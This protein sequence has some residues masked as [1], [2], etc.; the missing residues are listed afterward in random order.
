MSSLQSSV[1]RLL[2]GDY[3]ISYGSYL[4]LLVNVAGSYID[5]DIEATERKALNDLSAFL[6]KR[7]IVNNAMSEIRHTIVDGGISINGENCLEKM[8]GLV[9][10]LS[11]LDT[12]ID[13]ASLLHYV[14]RKAIEYG[15]WPIE[16]N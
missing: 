1:N 2:G 8:Y 3:P 11:K 14:K 5:D 4:E 9:Y 15:N 6:L 13:I 16:A 12:A 7:N 10:D